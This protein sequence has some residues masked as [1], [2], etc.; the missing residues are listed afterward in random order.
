MINFN[1]LR[2]FFFTAKLQSYTRA[3]QA[4]NITQPAVTAQIKNFEASLNLKLFRKRGR[5][6]YLTTESEILYAYARKIF[7]TEAEMED[8]I[9]QMQGL[10]RGVLR[11]GAAK[12]F[13]RYL[14]PYL[15]SSFHKAFPN[16]QIIVSEGSSR[17]MVNSLLEFKNDLAIIAKTEA[18]NDIR[19]IPLIRERVIAILPPNHRLAGKKAVDF[20]ELCREKIMM[21]EV[22]SGTRRLVDRL[23][24]ENECKP[25]VLMETSN[26]EFIKQLVQ[27]GEGI[28][29]LS[30]EAVQTELA[31]NTLASVN[32][33]H[34]DMF[35]DIHIAYIDSD[36]LSKAVSAFIA[37]IEAVKPE[38]EPIQR[39]DEILGLIKEKNAR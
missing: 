22:G 9:E 26:L 39:I 7:D 18:S 29:F 14:L 25:D 15:M 4:L 10:E 24:A 19:F 30:S 35:M 13:A 6:V 36:H 32:V 12:T 16:V 34:A 17:D 11:I 20:T 21:K 2:T 3:A 23:F 27:Q 5:K 38:G 1:Q 37:Y 28:S 31:V 8:A 33:K